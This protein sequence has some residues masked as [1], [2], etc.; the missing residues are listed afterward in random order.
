MAQ[1]KVLP[2]VG[3]LPQTLA[4]QIAAGEVIERPASVIKELVE[5]SLDAGAENVRIE[6]SRGGLGSM[7]VSDDGHGIHP[8][9]LE[10]ALERHA[11]SKVRSQEDLEGVASLG[12]RGE[13]LPSIASVATLRLI[14]RVAGERHGFYVESSPGGG[15]LPRRPAAHPPGTTV[16]IADLFDAFPARRKFLRSERSEYL[17]VLEVVR[18]LALSRSRVALKFSHDGSTVLQFPADAPADQRAGVIFGR[19]F[20]RNALPV[21]FSASGMRLWGWLGAPGHTRSQS[22]HQYLFLNGRSIR[23]R[24]ASHAIRTALEGVVPSGRFPV[25][26]LYLEMDARAAD[27]NVHPTKHEVR[28]RQGRDVHDFICASLR[29]ARSAPVEAQSRSGTIGTRPDVPGGGPAPRYPS[30]GPAPGSFPG[31]A[32]QVAEDGVEPQL[33][34]PLAQLNGEFLLTARGG[35]W[36]LVNLDAVR[37]LFTQTRLRQQLASG[38]VRSRPMLVPVELDM[39]AAEAML[40]DQYA[41]RLMQCG[42][43]LEP[44][45]PGRIAVRELPQLLPDADAVRLAR[46]IVAALRA[47]GPG[48]DQVDA[49]CE[50]MLQH[51]NP[52]FGLPRDPG[53]GTAELRALETLDLDFAAEEHPGLWRTLD[54][55]SL[56]DLLHSGR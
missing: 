11:T 1:S 23:D 16:E 37:R 25:Y 24:L 2:R 29:G 40:I 56:L 34:R 3:R 38:G 30:P 10:L 18:R 12:F 26:V 47:G 28:F 52:P 39:G 15:I 4:N 55:Q 36:L 8:D 6:I 50:V 48:T 5:N 17:H 7:R 20:R 51:C 31:A 33:G 54:R 43:R 21:D 35:K 53:P 44:V 19:A 49:I 14:S 32:F 27:V 46:D 9:D 22:D 45:A 13:A 41:S 42:L